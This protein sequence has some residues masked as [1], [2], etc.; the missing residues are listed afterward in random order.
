MLELLVVGVAFFMYARHATDGERVR[1]A[2]GQ[3]EV[4]VELA[5]NVIRTV[6]Q[7]QWVRVL[8]PA[9]PSAL[10]EISG[11]GQ[12]VLLGRHVRPEFRAVLAR[13]LASA[14]RLG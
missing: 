3:L 8:P 14:V 6:F 7:S 11:Q 9:T 4:E 10:I 13:E 2:Q 1:L 12:S 5:G